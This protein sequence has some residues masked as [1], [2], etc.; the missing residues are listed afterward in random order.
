VHFVDEN[1]DAGPIILQAV[2]PVLDND[3]ADTLSEKILREEHRI[4][5]E[6]VKIVLQGRFK[7]EGR[8]VIQ[9]TNQAAHR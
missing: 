1:L 4:Y 9:L 8:R 5:S 2:V 7:I 3:T 6:A